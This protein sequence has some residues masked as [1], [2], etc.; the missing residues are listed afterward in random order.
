MQIR[1]WLATSTLAAVLGLVLPED[2]LCWA[3]AG[4]DGF[5]GIPGLDGRPGQKGDM[6][7]PGKS[8]LRTGIRGPK[9]DAGEM[10]PPGIPGNRGYHG[11]HGAPGLPGKPGPKGNKGKAGNILE[12]PRPAFSASRRSPPSTGRTVVFDNIIT[13]E[14]SSYNPQTGEF[15][16]RVPGLYYFAY[17]VVSSGDLCLSI[18]KNR[19]H[20]VSFCDHNSH[21]LLQVNSGSSVL[22]LAVGDRVSVS[23]D[24]ARGS[25]IYSGSEAD[26]VFSGFMLFPQTG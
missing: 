20:V 7:E 13:N 26:S 21:K 16:C 14:E 10:G 8:A 12:Q 5:P 11:P 4:K 15:T 18:T 25:M 6:G 19:E 3:P 23:T 17:Q 9:G 24:P 22:S 1:L 2:G